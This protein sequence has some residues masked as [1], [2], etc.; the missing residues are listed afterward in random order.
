MLIAAQSRFRTSE[1]CRKSGCYE[2]DGYLDGGSDYLPAL[3]EMEVQ[4]CAGEPF[5]AVSNP[6]RACFWTTAARPAS[7]EGSV[8]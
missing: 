6:S 5:P 2:F 3:E 7:G 1:S 4:V 8:T